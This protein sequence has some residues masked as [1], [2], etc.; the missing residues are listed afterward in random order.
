MTPAE[1][2]YTALEPHLQLQAQK[3]QTILRELEKRIVGQTHVGRRLLAAMIAQ[4]HVLLEGVP[5]LAKTTA[6][7]ALSDATSLSFKRVQF[8]PDLLPADVIGTQ[9][10]DP[11]TSEFR[12]KKGPIFANL[13]L[14]DE[15]NRAPAKVQSALLEAMQERQVTIG[16]QTWPLEEPFL[17]MATQNPID[18]EGTYALPEAQVD[19]FLF[20]VLVTYGTKEEEREIIVRSA[21]ALEPVME[22]VATKQDIRELR[23]WV[24]RV[25]IADKIRTY[26]VDLVFATRFPAQYGLTE[27]ATWIESGA[28]PRA[29][30]NLDRGA[31]V[32]ALMEGRAY[33]T[34]QDVKDIGADILRH[35]IR[36]TYEAEAAGITVDEIIRRIFDR[37]AVP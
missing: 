10:Y 35:R 12:V 3:A 17:V 34:P 22:K 27:L 5:G 1:I 6:I 13:V 11:R 30:I 31:R 18:Q 7:K 24:D 28:S 4:G 26:I 29:S 9:I 19:R 20:K 2:D 16:D 8:T 32:N 33:V 37:V 23:Q 25:Y 21:M 36:R 15:I 14:A